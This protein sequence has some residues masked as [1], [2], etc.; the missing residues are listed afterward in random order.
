M[1]SLE[2][3]PDPD[4]LTV[5]VGRDPDGT[6]VITLTGALDLTGTAAAERAFASLPDAGPAAGPGAVV[7]DVAGLT[8]MDS[9]G[10]TVLVQAVRR[11][12]VLRLRRP[13]PNIER[14]IAATGLSELLPIEP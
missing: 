4:E 10:L 3:H 6:P 8:F 2:T 7:A 1:D 9:S 11:G 5:S 13:S 12:Q 14:L